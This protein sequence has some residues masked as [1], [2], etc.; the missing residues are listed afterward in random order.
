MIAGALL[1]TPAVRGAPTVVAAPAAKF[2]LRVPV[3]YYHHILCPPADATIPSLYECPD[4][5]TAQLSYL[6]DNGWQAITVDQVADLIAARQCP[7][8]KQFVI[9]MDDGAVDGYDNAAPILESLG[10][11][12][13]FFVTSG[14]PGG[15][16]PGKIDWDQLRDLVAR[17]HAIGNHTETHLNLK[18]QP[19]AVLYDQIEGAQQIFE[20]ELGFRPRT[21]AYPYGRYNDSVIAQVAASDFELAFTVHAGAKEATDTPFESKRIEVLSTDTGADVLAK[22]QPFANACR[23]AA[24]D[25]SLALASAGPFKGDNI[26]KPS[27]ARTQTIQRTGVKVG[28]TYR[29]WV[30]L[31]N[32]EQKAGAFSVTSTV[33]GTAGMTVRYSVAG[34]DISAA[35]AAGTYKSPVVEPWTAITIVV[36]VT[37][38]H[39]GSA[40]ASTV[41]VL[42]ATSLSD[43]TRVDV[44][45][46]ITAY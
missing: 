33:D 4:Q 20:D 16:R 32:D 17:G 31:E 27:V 23:A 9:S 8:P 25:I 42:R 36:R 5:F 22:I 40:G 37:P 46:I 38:T 13:T 43:P 29:Y 10:M 1:V 19:P 15:L 26:Y 39:P 34:T 24:P 2:E 7:Q 44:G 28:K 14:L 3:L 45:R 30:R 6:K 21:F 35:M 18:V 12:G 41:V 11:R